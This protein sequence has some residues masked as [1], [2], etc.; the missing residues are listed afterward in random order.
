MYTACYVKINLITILAPISPNLKF[1]LSRKEFYHHLPTTNWYDGGLHE[2]INHS[3]SLLRLLYI[4]TFISICHSQF[5]FILYLVSH[6]F[7]YFLFLANPAY[8]L[9]DDSVYICGIIPFAIL[10]TLSSNTKFHLIGKKFYYNLP[11]AD[12]YDWDIYE[13]T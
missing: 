12:R 8:W 2:K 7:I 1:N 4:I 9:H 11:T 6:V 10:A 13:K 5:Y 3:S